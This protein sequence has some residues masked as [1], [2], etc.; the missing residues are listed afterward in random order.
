MRTRFKRAFSPTDI[1]FD[2]NAKEWKFSTDSTVNGKPVDRESD[3]DDN[4]KVAAAATDGDILKAPETSDNI[5]TAS[6]QVDPM[7]VSNEEGTAPTKGGR[8]LKSLREKAW[9]R[10]DPKDEP[11]L[12]WM[13][14]LLKQRLDDEN[15]RSQEETALRARFR[16]AFY[17]ADVTYD[18][19][20]EEWKILT[21]STTDDK[22]GD[23]ESC[24]DDD[25]KVARAETMW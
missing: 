2:E 3:N 21:K 16:G 25:A 11:P 8:L 14:I 18:N 22:A 4:E 20:A 24:N 23:T 9:K 6:S 5:D 15:E 17:P 19:E 12:R 13:H 7:D 1:T 10:V